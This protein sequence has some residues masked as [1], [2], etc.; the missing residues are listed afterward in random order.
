[1][2]TLLT[3]YLLLVLLYADFCIM[4]DWLVTSIVL[5]S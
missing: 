1:M 3:F 5:V 2:L 4:Y